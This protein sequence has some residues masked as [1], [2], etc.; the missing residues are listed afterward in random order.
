[1]GLVLI[2]VAGVLIGG[3]IS[4]RRQGK[5]LGLQVVLGIGALLLLVLA[6]QAEPFR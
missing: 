4:F 1:M 6:A 5:P 2:A 3:V